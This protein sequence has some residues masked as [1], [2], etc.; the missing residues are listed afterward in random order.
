MSAAIK[1]SKAGRDR[2]AHATLIPISF[3]Y[4]V[5][6]SSNEKAFS[7]CPVVVSA[8]A[9][10]RQPRS[11]LELHYPSW[12]ASGRNDSRRSEP[13][14]SPHAKWSWCESHHSLFGPPRRNSCEIALSITSKR[15]IRPPEYRPRLSPLT[16]AL[17]GESCGRGKWNAGFSAC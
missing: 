5:K 8:M 17:I 16:S 12:H 14:I 10:F 11:R 9:M 3:Q 13:R 1:F 2:K 7:G 6:Y 15:L 4:R